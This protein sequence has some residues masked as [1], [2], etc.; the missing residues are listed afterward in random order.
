MPNAQTHFEARNLDFF[1]IFLKQYKASA[2]H[3]KVYILDVDHERE[4]TKQ[5][6]KHRLTPLKFLAPPQ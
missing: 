2:N 4:P 3:S 5:E 6:T 1:N